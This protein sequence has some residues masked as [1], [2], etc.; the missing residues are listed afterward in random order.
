MKRLLLDIE[1]APNVAHVW[2]LWDQNIGLTQLLASGYVL[3]WAAK[4]VGEEE[5]F[6][7]SIH[8]SKPKKMLKRIHSL[9]DECDVVIHYNGKKF[10]IPT[11]NK[12]FL[13]HG[14]S[15]PAPYKQVDL[16]QVAKS[17]F[18]FPSNKLAYIAKELGVT[19]KK[20]NRGHE[21]WIGCMAGDPECWV[22]MEDYNRGDVVSLEE[23]YIKMLPWI[24]IHPNYGLYDKPGRPVC[25]NCGSNRLQRRGTARTMVN[26]YHR[27]QC[28]DCGSWMKDSVSIMAKSDKDNVMRAAA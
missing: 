5:I 10:D 6:F 26:E 13:L 14:L 11:L 12:E 20:N 17:T 16:C 1:T 19:E 4:W 7:D 25:T 22:E 3:C 28:K 9:L 15:P 27:Y 24:K 21:L 8:Q 2:G 18:R 23:V